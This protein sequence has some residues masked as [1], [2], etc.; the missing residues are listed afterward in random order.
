MDSLTGRITRLI[1]DQQL[2]TIAAEDG[3][4]YLFDSHSLLGTTFAM[5]H[6]GAPVTFVPN[7]ATRRA[8]VVRITVPSFAKQKPL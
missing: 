6:V 8:G 3:V 5:L 4:D 2:G 1:D 7:A